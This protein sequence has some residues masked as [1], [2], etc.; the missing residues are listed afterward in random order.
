MSSSKKKGQVNIVVDA[1]SRRYALIS[2][3]NAR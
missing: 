3:L 2:I 1:L